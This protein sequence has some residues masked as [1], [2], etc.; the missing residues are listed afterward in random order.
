[1]RSGDD[2]SNMS[3][4]GKYIYYEISILRARINISQ[5][6]ATQTQ[7]MSAKAN[8]EEQNIR[9]MTHKKYT[10]RGNR[11]TPIQARETRYLM[12]TS[13]CATGRQQTEVHTSS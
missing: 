10:C 13:L 9:V 12:Y 11:D 2:I 4:P 6:F 3:V 5:Y 8:L 1:M 7:L